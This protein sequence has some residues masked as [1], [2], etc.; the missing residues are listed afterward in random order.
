MGEDTRCAAMQPVLL[1]L[2]VMRWGC[3]IR[4]AIERDEEAIAVWKD[5]VWPDIKALRASWAPTSV[6]GW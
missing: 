2:A 6:S 5:Q 4:Q 3:A 1:R